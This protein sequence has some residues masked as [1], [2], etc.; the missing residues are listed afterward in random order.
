MVL[1]ARELGV[2]VLG[3]LEVRLP[4]V[5]RGAPR[6]T[7]TNGKTT[8]T[9]FGR[10]FSKTRAA[11]CTWWETSVSPS[12]CGAGDAPTDVTVCEV[13]SFQLETVKEFH[14]PGV[15]DPQHFRGPPEPPRA[16]WRPTSP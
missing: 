14:P 10:N 13:S 6:H 16:T 1:K 2:E 8:T 3:E 5:V 15:R 7:G 11:A 4:R 12:G 9:T